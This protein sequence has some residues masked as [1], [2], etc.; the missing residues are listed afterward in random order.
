[1]PSWYIHCCCWNQKIPASGSSGEQPSLAWA[2]YLQPHSL[3]RPFLTL[4]FS[5]LPSLVIFFTAQTL[6]FL[7]CRTLGFTE[8]SIE[9]LCSMNVPKHS[10]KQLAH[11]ALFYRWRNWGTETLNNLFKVILLVSVQAGVQIRQCSFRSIFLTSILPP[12]K[13]Q[14]CI[15][16]N[17][18]DK[19]CMLF[20]LGETNNLQIFTFYLV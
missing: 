19:E 3:T 13:E 7:C 20:L 1:M 10:S 12:I 6:L 15:L 4:H 8:S 9:S 18:D 11:S 2:R 14:E 5:H 17:I 16:R